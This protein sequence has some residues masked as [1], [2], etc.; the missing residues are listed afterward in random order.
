MPSKGHDWLEKEHVDKGTIYGYPYY[1]I[2]IPP[3]FPEE[4]LS[5]LKESNHSLYLALLDTPMVRGNYNGYLVFPNRPVKAQSHH[6]ILEYVPVHGGITYAR[7]APD[8][9]MVYGFDT[10]HGYSP[11][12][13]SVDFIVE[14]LRYML[15][16]ILKAAEV[17]PVYLA[18]SGFSY[19]EKKAAVL[20]VINVRGEGDNNHSLGM[21]L[22]LLT[23]KL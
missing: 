3:A 6:G 20:S 8:G 17:E 11:R 16:G 1:V 18:K 2:E 7:Q 23:G 5:G 13:K 15:A 22:N 10:A 21:I 9:R 4:M 14:E 19:A 12:L